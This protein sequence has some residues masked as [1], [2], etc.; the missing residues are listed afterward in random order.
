VPPLS[1]ELPLR[2]LI[3]TTNPKD[4]RMLDVSRELAPV[5]A[6]LARDGFDVRMVDEPQVDAIR[7][8]LADWPPHIFHYIGHG[9]ISH[10][11]GSLIVSDVDMQSFWVTGAQLAEALPSC[12]RLLCLSTCFTTENFQLLGLARLA[13][14]ANAGHL[15][16]TITNQYPVGEPAVWSFWGTFYNALLEERGDVNEAVQ[17]ARLAVAHA[18]P[19]SADWGSFSLVI[20]DQT[21]IAFDLDESTPARVRE[22]FEAQYV[23]Q[24]VNELAEQL[25]VFGPAVPP[26]LRRQFDSKRDRAS[27]LIDDLSVEGD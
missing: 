24:L 23:T 13:R 3:V 26:T 15:P 8:L 27:K 11:D 9:G 10:G 22:E 20:R 2:V 18:E 4:A 14:A 25:L 21:G 16:T 12:V 1:A 5:M 17:R 6:G 19:D 7:R